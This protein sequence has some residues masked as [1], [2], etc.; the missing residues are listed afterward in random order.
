[1]TKNKNIIIGIIIGVLCS[2]IGLVITLL[3]LGQGSTLNESLDIAFN[4]GIFTKL[5]ILGALVNLATFF[6]FIYKDNND[7]A[8]GV[9]IATIGVAI[10]TA[11]M[12]F[13]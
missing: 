1:M 3:L 7:R 9:L 11:I 4:R 12:R 10:F 5:M 2:I 13:I 6:F 8:Q